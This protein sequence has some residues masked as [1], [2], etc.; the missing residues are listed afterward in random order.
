MAHLGLIAVPF[1]GAVDDLSFRVCKENVDLQTLY[2]SRYNILNNLTNASNVIRAASCAT[3]PK[4]W[5]GWMDE[6]AD[7]SEQG[8]QAYQGPCPR[9]V[10]VYHPDVEDIPDDRKSRHFFQAYQSLITAPRPSRESNKEP[11][12]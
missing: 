7:G 3:W 10:E 8:N 9:Q 5:I 2:K 1:A 11:R 12:E 4:N 6:R